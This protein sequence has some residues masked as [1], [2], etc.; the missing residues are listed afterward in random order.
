MKARHRWCVTSRKRLC[1][2]GRGRGRRVVS[3]RRAAM[4]GAALAAPRPPRKARGNSSSK[5]PY[6]Q[7]SRKSVHSSECS[8]R[9]FAPNTSYRKVLLHNCGHHLHWQSPRCTRMPIRQGLKPERVRAA[10]CGD[11]ISN[12]SHEGAGA[13]LCLQ[14]D[15][16]HSHLCIYLL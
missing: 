4:G 12:I 3:G 13:S 8:R 14:T 10:L 5:N 6:G 16:L 11:L 7:S 9:C 1:G 2:S 15:S